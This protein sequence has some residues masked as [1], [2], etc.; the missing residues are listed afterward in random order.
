MNLTVN[1]ER[2]MELLSDI[3]SSNNSFD[4]VLNRV[5]LSAVEPVPV[6][7]LPRSTSG[8]SVQ[9]PVVKEEVLDLLVCHLVKALSSS[10]SDPVLNDE[11]HRIINEVDS[12]PVMKTASDKALVKTR[13]PRLMVQDS[14]SG[15]TF[16]VGENSHDFLFV[17][18]IGK[19]SY[20]TYENR[21]CCCSTQFGD[22]GFSFFGTCESENGTKYVAFD[23]VWVE[24]PSDQKG[25][26]NS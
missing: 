10:K 12:L 14:L 15:T 1:V 22:E 23:T 8:V 21:Q 24:A 19:G 5:I 11:L 4:K 26:S 25:E 6:S 2:L 7:M 18:R 20:I 9:T 16:R 13:Y 3:D 17:S